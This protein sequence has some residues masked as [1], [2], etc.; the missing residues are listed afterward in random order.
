[1]RYVLNSHAHFDHAGGIAALARLS[2]A[3]V[4]ASPLAAQGLR[5][6]SALYDDPQ[7]GYGA[8]MNFAPVAKVREFAD[9]ETLTLGG[10]TLTAHHTP[11]HTPGGTSWSW[12][13]CEDGNCLNV[14]YGDSLNPVSA[15][16][17]R[18]FKRGGA[19]SP[20]SAALQTSIA[21]MRALRCDV[22]VT[23]HPDGSRLLER[24]AKAA[25]ADA[26]DAFVD[27]R[28]CAAYANTAAQRLQT[29]REEERAP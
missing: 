23:V 5:S 10:V 8:E 22:L 18:F 25:S 29:R 11:G 15:P 16:D 12:R 19:A 14:V 13:S 1:V 28:A 27:R 3:T 2:G 17:F 9:G 24:Q 21:T 20:R 26:Y 6:G 7:L 4:G